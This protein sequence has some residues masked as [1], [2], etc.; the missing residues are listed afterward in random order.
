MIEL[1]G[2]HL[3]IPDVITVAREY[4]TVTLSDRAKQNM[5]QSQQLVMDL[6]H[7]G[8]MLPQYVAAALANEKAETDLILSQEIQN[9]LIESASHFH[10]KGMR[11]TSN[12]DQFGVWYPSRY[13]L[14]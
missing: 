11:A 6:L 13:I 5:E 1:D 7:S 4:K 2:N 10:E 12:F 9:L 8:L 3:T 14:R